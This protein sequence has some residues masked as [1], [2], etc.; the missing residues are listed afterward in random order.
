M[1]KLKQRQLDILKLFVTSGKPINTQELCEKF[2]KSERT[3]HYDVIEIKNFLQKNNIEL[4]MKSKQ[5]YYIP[6]SE[7]ILCVNLV[8]TTDDKKHIAS[9][10]QR[11]KLSEE[12]LIYLSIKNRAISI[13]ECLQDLAISQS[14]FIRAVNK[15]NESRK[16]INIIKCKSGYIL[17][18][19]EKEL[20]YEIAMLLSS[21][22]EGKTIINEWFDELPYVLRNMFTIDQLI[23]V[24][25]SI[26]EVNGK[27]NVWIS[28][29]NF[30]N[31]SSY[32]LIQTFRKHAHKCV[33]DEVEDLE[34]FNYAYDILRKVNHTDTIE[35]IELSLLVDYMFRNG[36]ITPT[37]KTLFYSIE[38]D[39]NNI[40]D[41]IESKCKGLGLV[42][43]INELKKDLQLHLSHYLKL[44]KYNLKFE[45]V[46]VTEEIKVK[47]KNLFEIASQSVNEFENKFN[48]EM[49]D[50]ELSYIAI[51]I[52]KNILN[53][54]NDLTRVY[55]VC[56]TGKGL[57]NLLTTRI[58][59]VFPQLEIVGQTSAFGLSTISEKVDF[60]ISTV[61]LP[62]ITTP[63]VKIS[64][65]LADDD[66]QR[67][68]GFINFGKTENKYSFQDNKLFYNKKY[69]PF[70]LVDINMESEKAELASIS[71]VIAKLTLTLL[72]YVSMIGEGLSLNSDILLGLV[73]H[74]NMAIPRWFEE[75]ETEIDE[76]VEKGYELIMNHYSEIYRKME[77]FF[78][79]VEK[80]LLVTI[81]RK[82][83]YAF[84]MYLLNREEIENEDFN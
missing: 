35:A 2:D 22:F 84:Y 17:G 66:I 7:K 48:T 36:V 25:E 32:C 31:I 38:N 15:I 79:L 20:R 82:E 6:A 73:I 28:N 52:Y 39:V 69:D 77:K 8:N 23:D 60:I 58:K 64:V 53:T 9:L 1:E 57:S 40:V 41:K 49:N 12:I 83:R 13:E 5:G 68:Q 42:L 67:I 62:E 18:G 3:I 61:D 74:M 70:N 47:Y 54:K 80:S 30:L 71:G 81:S 11:K 19:E 75:K 55:I 34:E 37:E 56:A 16:A 46:Y 76:E 27:Y 50:T 33:K 26:K 59:N 78:E 24:S 21:Y 43:S 51:Y 10:Y 29:K 14:T 45:D 63:V 4:K 44:E 72:E 65:I